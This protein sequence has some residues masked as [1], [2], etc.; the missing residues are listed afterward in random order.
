MK[1]AL[2][3]SAAREWRGGYPTILQNGRLRHHFVCHFRRESSADPSVPLN[4]IRLPPPEQFY[5][6]TVKTRVEEGTR[7][8]T[9]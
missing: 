9:S 7:P 8:S 6:Q 1:L 5:G 3:R 4:R 2:G